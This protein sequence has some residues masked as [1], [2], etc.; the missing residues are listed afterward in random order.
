[1]KPK[2]AITMGDPAGIGAEIAVK[3]L[4]DSAMYDISVPFVI[5]DG[6]AMQDAIDFTK[7]S[8]SLRTISH[9][10][11]AEG[12]YGV[13]ESSFGLLDSDLK[14]KQHYETILK[15]IQDELQ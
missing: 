7:S 10:D 5:G 8:L 9:P 11:E 14:P 4:G 15:G 1:M 3:A 12:K 13:I 2:L 6:E